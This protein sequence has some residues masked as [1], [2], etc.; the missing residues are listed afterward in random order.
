MKRYG[1]NGASSWKRERRPPAPKPIGGQDELETLLEGPK[2][3]YKGRK[4]PGPREDPAPGPPKGATREVSP[5]AKERSR[6]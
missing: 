6:E 5:T 2:E 3:T 4:G 1:N